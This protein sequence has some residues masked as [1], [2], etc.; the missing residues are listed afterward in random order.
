MIS[1][2]RHLTIK[3]NGIKGSLRKMAMPVQWKLA[4]KGLV[5][6]RPRKVMKIFHAN[7]L[8]LLAMTGNESWPR[9]VIKR[10]WCQAFH[11]LGTLGM[12][13]GNT[14]S[15]DHRHYRYHRHQL[16]K[17][18]II[19]CHENWSWLIDWPMN[20]FCYSPYL[21]GVQQ[22]WR[23]LVTTITLSAKIGKLLCRLPA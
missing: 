11:E 21:R 7:C 4:I 23:H 3:G 17:E 2:P 20:H 13:D 22:R 8:W 19:Y 14:R 6:K 5:R 9:Q 10:W 16:C 18:N 12:N 15:H 1:W